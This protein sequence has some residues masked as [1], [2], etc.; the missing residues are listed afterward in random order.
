M[1]ISHAHRAEWQRGSEGGPTLW[2]ASF[3]F[4]D[5]LSLT[6]PTATYLVQTFGS[7]LSTV[8]AY[9]ASNTSG[10]TKKVAHALM[11]ALYLR[12]LHPCDARSR[13]MR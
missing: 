12:R 9:N 10:H 8:Y 1:I 6:P 5:V 7:A 3:L 2:S 11:F 4:Q 13:S